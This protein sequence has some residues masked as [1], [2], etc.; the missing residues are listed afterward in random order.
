MILAGNVG[1][2]G[3]EAPLRRAGVIEFDL[4]ENSTACLRFL[5]N[6][7]PWNKRRVWFRNFRPRPGLLEMLRSSLAP[8]GSKSHRLRAREFPHPCLQVPAFAK[9]AQRWDGT[10]SLPGL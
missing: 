7:L 9:R 2:L 5:K 4:W 6:V 3:P 10:S 1:A 8:D